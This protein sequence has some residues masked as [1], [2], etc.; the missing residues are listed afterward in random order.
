MTSAVIVA[1]S[2][3]ETSQEVRAAVRSA[4]CFERSATARPPRSY[5][6][7]EDGPTSGICSRHDHG[8]KL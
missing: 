5:R 4:P 2:G 6:P 7:H 3:A 8:R 1:D